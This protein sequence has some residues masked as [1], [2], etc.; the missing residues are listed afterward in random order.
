MYSLSPA[1]R[2]CTEECRVLGHSDQCWMPPLASPASSSDYRSNLY[3]PGE[4]SHQACDPS[5]EKS[6]QP[7]T[8]TGLTRNQSFSTFGKDLGGEEDREE[9]E[10]GA[11]VGEAGDEDLCG[12]T[13]LLSEMSSVFQRLLPQGLDSYVQVNEN[14]KGT[15]L[16]GVGV[17]MTGSLDRR[18]G[19]LP[20]KP[21]PSVHQQGV[22]AWAANTH[23]QNPGS[24]IGP[25]GPHQGGSYHTLK[26]STKLSSQSGHK[27]TQAPKNSPQNSGHTPKPH[28]SPL[29]TALVSPTLLHPSPAPVAVALCPSSKWL[30]AMEEIPENYEED[31]FDSGRGPLQ[32]R[33]CDSRHELVDASE[34]V[35]EINKLLQDVRQS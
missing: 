20:G 16:S 21:N 23:F 29:L 7:C 33:R 27:G 18:R 9:V 22:A 15:G 25:S 31:D 1:M 4:E 5:Q 14:Q 10:G 6:P 24:S 12:T 26:P 35:A 34:L 19:H 11:C 13:S 17:P 30:P 8:D 32:G 3:I 28:S 2:L